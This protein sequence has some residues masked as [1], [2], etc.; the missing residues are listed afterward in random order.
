VTEK[1]PGYMRQLVE[2]EHV[3][4]AGYDKAVITLS[5]G[6]L[7]LS[8]AFVKDIVPP[9]EAVARNYLLA[10]WLSW[11]ASLSFLLV[12]YYVGQMTYRFRINRLAKRQEPESDTIAIFTRSTY[13]LSAFAGLSFL[14]GVLFIVSFVYKNLGTGNV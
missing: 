12:A 11:T 6:A 2:G 5:G 3:V 7:G 14:A 13:W 9:A 8:L 4:G 1:K 10:S